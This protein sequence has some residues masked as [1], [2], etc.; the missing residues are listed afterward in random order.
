M[1]EPDRGAEQLGADAPPTPA[2]PPADP[3][4]S[5]PHKAEPVTRDAIELSD[6]QML[7][8]LALGNVVIAYDADDPPPALVQLQEDTAGPFD[9]ELAAA[10]QAVILARRPG[11]GGVVALAW[12]RKLEADRAGRPEAARV[13]RGLPRPGA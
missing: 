10:G 9:A 8:A 6:D 7:E 5:G 1:L 11:V 12:R 2:S 13:R 4:T 3:P